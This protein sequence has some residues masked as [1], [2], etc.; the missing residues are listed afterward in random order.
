MRK[1]ITE[2][3]TNR[4]GIVL[5]ALNLCFF[6]SRINNFNAPPIGKLFVYMNFPAIG[7]TILSLNFIKT[8]VYQFSPWAEVNLGNVLFASFIILQWLFIALFA[9]TLARRLQGSK[10]TI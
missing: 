1:V 7:S 6:A 8:F 9:K 2:L 10:F 3:F 4:F 5:A